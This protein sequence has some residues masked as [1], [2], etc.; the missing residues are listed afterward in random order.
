LLVR[1]YGALKCERHR[2]DAPARRVNLG[3]GFDV[4]LLKIEPVPLFTSGGEPDRLLA[5]LLM[6]RRPPLGVP[7]TAIP[8]T[9][10]RFAASVN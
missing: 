8:M 3:D 2:K 10:Q 9:G 6:H 5:G 7:A 1:F 4:Q